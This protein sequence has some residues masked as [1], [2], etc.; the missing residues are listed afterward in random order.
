M[1]SRSSQFSLRKSLDN[2]DANRRETFFVLVWFG[3]KYTS[4]ILEYECLKSIFLAEIR[5]LANTLDE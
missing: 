3:R 2:I 4:H 1:L 5:Y